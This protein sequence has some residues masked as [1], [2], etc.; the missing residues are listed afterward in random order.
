MWGSHE[1]LAVI[2]APGK[3]F[4]IQEKKQREQLRDEEGNEADPPSRVDLDAG[5]AVIR[6]TPPAKPA[7][8]DNAAES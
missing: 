4:E 8:D 6:I 7:A 2:F 1:D 5:V 3:R